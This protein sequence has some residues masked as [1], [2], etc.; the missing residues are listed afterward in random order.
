LT[1]KLVRN[2]RSSKNTIFTTTAQV[3]KP[4]EKYQ[5]IN[6]KTSKAYQIFFK[7]IKTQINIGII[8]IGIFL[9]KQIKRISNTRLNKI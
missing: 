2:L 7:T 8:N 1:F 9:P 3:K 4:Y 6:Q 5:K